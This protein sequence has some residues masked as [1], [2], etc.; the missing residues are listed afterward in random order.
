M[1]VELPSPDAM[2]QSITNIH[3]QNT[4]VDA[5]V[6]YTS[7]RLIPEPS[8]M[9]SRAMIDIDESIRKCKI[10]FGSWPRAVN[11]VYS[12][13]AEHYGFK[14]EPTTLS[15]RVVSHSQFPPSGTFC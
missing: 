1:S 10:V 2:V 8:I 4:N 14:I 3:G 11:A 7:Y 13:L 12:D 5:A 6:T 9:S 15:S